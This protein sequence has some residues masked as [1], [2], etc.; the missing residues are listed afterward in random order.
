MRTNARVRQASTRDRPCSSYPL[1]AKPLPSR[2]LEQIAF[3]LRLT[4][5]SRWRVSAL[6]PE[7]QG[8]RR[9]DYVPLLQS[10]AVKPYVEGKINN[11]RLQLSK[12]ASRYSLSV[13]LAVL[14]FTPILL[15]SMLCRSAAAQGIQQF[16][17][18]VADPSGAAVPGA[19]WIYDYSHA[20]VKVNHAQGKRYQFGES[21]V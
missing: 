4:K 7:S 11:M 15:A 19:T 5:R 8:Q 3:Q 16:V 20:G 13:R 9:A 14:C 6:L 18:H 12:N 2:S 17:G 21:H 10:A 1:A